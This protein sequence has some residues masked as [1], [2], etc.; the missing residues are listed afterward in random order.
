MAAA[1]LYRSAPL[2]FEQPTVGYRLPPPPTSPSLTIYHLLIHLISSHLALGGLC[3]EGFFY[4]FTFGVFGLGFLFDLFRMPALVRAANARAGF[5]MGTDGQWA[6]PDGGGAAREEAP[7]YR[8]P[9]AVP[10]SQHTAIAIDP[11]RPPLAQP[12]PQLCV[13][14]LDKP[15]SECCAVLLLARAPSHPQL[16]IVL[17]LWCAWYVCGGAD[18]LLGCGHSCLCLTCG[19]AIM[20]KAEP[21]CPL[22]RAPITTL[23]AARAVH[24][25]VPSLAP[26]APPAV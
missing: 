12:E 21:T 24:A 10:P 22:C 1:R 23:N 26:S 2:L 16:I 5:V 25:V 19:S 20:N 4:F 7:L 6:L 14:C 18:T 17:W 13:V 11:T 15:I 3:V 9:G 8:P